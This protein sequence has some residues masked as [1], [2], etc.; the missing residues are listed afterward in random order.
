MIYSTRVSSLTLPSKGSS[1]K[2][3]DINHS[4]FAKLDLTDGKALH[5]KLVVCSFLP[6]I[7]CVHTLKCFLLLSSYKVILLRY[8]VGAHMVKFRN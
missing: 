3:Q 2:E 4:K 8:A 5:A 7:F 1:L 6:L